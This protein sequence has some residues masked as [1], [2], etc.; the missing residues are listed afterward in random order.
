MS[1]VQSNGAQPGQFG[2][3]GD[4]WQCL[5]T[6]LVGE[7][8][9]LASS[10]WWPSVTSAVGRNPTCSSEEAL[11]GASSKRQSATRKPAAH[12]ARQKAGQR[13]GGTM[14]TGFNSLHLSS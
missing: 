12:T 3:P 8:A 6:F 10:G 11:S 13:K 7:R 14:S 4:I 5:G 9:L 1:F 2:P